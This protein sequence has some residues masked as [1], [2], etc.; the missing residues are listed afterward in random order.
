M[1]IRWSLLK[2]LVVLPRFSNAGRIAE[3][4]AVFDFRVCERVDLR[5]FGFAGLGVSR[6]PPRGG[7]SNKQWTQARGSG[8]P[9]QVLAADADQLLAREAVDE[10]GDEVRDLRVRA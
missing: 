8:G 9:V 10:H 1:L 3:S 6:A 7:R 2:G 4:A 5:A